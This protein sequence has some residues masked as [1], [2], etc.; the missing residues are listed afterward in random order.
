MTVFFDRQI[1]VSVAGLTLEDIRIQFEV[2][3][4]TDTTQVKGFV[5]LF[6]LSSEKEE[7]IYERGA[8]IQVSAGYPQTQALILDGHVQRVERV[9]E[10]LSKITKLKIGDAT[11]EPKTLAGVTSIALDGY[12]SVREIARLIARDIKIPIAEAS[13][14]LIPN[15]ALVLNYAWSGPS[16]AAL[17][18][19]LERVDCTH[20]EADGLIR[21]N[22]INMAQPDA[23]KIIVSPRNGLIGTPSIV[24]VDDDKEGAE[25]RM[26]LNPIVVIGSIINL[27]SA[28]VKGRWKVVGVKH[29]GD[30]WEGSFETSVEL[31][32]LTE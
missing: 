6:N 5:N 24:D 20:Y 28:N 17:R 14:E 30:N 21:I 26:F 25:A 9:R 29:R 31:R 11:R 32:A 7:R 3:R 12:E 15:D 27:D 18:R 22:R 1:T 4:S 8:K 23:V 13:L 10:S 16:D 19:L 2:E